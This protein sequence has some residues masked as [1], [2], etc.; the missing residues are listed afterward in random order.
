MKYQ[1]I[2]KY[3]VASETATVIKEFH[4]GA[5][6]AVATSPVNHFAATGGEDGSVRCW[7]YVEQKCKYFK[8]FNSSVSA[9]SWGPELMDKSGK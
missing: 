8:K 7:D 9:L 5:V 4:S 1:I 3:D 6:N 2:W